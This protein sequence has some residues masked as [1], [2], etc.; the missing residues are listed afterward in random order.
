MAGEDAMVSFSLPAGSYATVLLHE[1]MKS[2]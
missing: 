1:L 2:E